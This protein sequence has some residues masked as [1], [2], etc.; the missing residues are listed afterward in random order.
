MILDAG[1]VGKT[2]EGDHG[3]FGLLVRKYQGPTHA[4]I[5]H[6]TRDAAVT[7]EIAQDVFVAAYQKLAQLKDA[8]RFGG[9]LRAIALNH[10]RMWRRSQKSGPRIVPLLGEESVGLE[11]AR[12][13]AAARE[14]ERPLGIE[15]MIRRLPAKLQ[16]AALLCL[17]EELSPS[18]A[19]AVLGLKPGTLRKRLHAAR[20]KL[21]RRIVETAEQEFRMHLLPG[22][23]AERCIC[24]CEKSRRE[25]P[26]REVRLMSKKVDC[27]C[28]CVGAGKDRPQKKPNARKKARK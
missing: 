6:F 15:S 25:K 14:P 5:R 20:A 16:T 1:L 7:D 19:A 23:F 8:N 12:R 22:D 17:D 27:G 13:E 28:G 3:A 11:A 2:L 24:R 9:W 21:Q 18:A 26:I 10:C 4:L